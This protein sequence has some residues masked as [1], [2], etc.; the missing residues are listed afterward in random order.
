MIFLVTGYH[1]STKIDE[2][3]GFSES[4]TTNLDTIMMSQ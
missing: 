1:L 3:G 2:N 4:E